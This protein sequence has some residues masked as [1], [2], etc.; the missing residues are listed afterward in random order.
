MLKNPRTS[1]L[2][3]VLAPLCYFGSMLIAG[4]LYPGFSHVSQLPS[5]L[6]A[7]GSPHP[8]IFNVGLV[9][10]GLMLLLAAPALAHTVIGLG[11]SK[12]FGTAIIV[13]LLPP[14]VYFP[15]VGL[16]PLPDP[17]HNA[18]FPLLLPLQVGPFVLAL[19]LLHR[20]EASSLIRY[21]LATGAALVLLLLMAL[22]VGG[23]V[24][25]GNQGLFI[26][27]HALVGFSWLAV[28]GPILKGWVGARG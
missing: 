20:R 16:I 22:G 5:D 4:L 17:R 18:L 28:A 1:L 19:S 25:A 7:V 11:A 24:N 8:M 3:T 14:A 27:I 23:V 26:R 13:T 6:G 2:A 12:L 9:L 10:T 21:L 15:L